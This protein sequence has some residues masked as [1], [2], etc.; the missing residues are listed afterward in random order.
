MI[1]NDGPE[2]AFVFEGGGS[3]AATQ[4]GMLRALTEAEVAPD[5]AVG[6][7]AGAINAVPADH[8]RHRSIGSSAPRFSA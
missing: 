5:W 7:S 8:A 4:V 3:L 2:K 1:V 6:S